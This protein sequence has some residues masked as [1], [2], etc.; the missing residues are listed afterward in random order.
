[1]KMNK[2]DLQ[3]MLEKSVSAALGTDTQT[4]QQTSEVSALAKSINALNAKVD[5][6]VDAASNG[7]EKPKTMEDH[8]ADMTK[9][10]KDAIGNLNKT[11][12]DKTSE[13]VK[14]PETAEELQK[15]IADSVAKALE[16]T[17]KV[18]TPKGET[19]E[20]D[21]VDP[22][23]KAIEDLDEDGINKLAK[24]LL[25]GSG[26]EGI[27]MS[28]D[29]IKETEDAAGNPLTALQKA[30]RAKLDDHFGKIISHSQ[31]RATGIDEEEEEDL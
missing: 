9:S 25:S 7:F 23:T 27:K 22:L 2:T 14:L 15:M 26:V 28:D 21:T 16:K 12:E 13:E 1:M 17:T 31:Q 5:A 30:K 4:E 6:I 20:D 3:A 24:D 18:E 11:T 8:F 29:L 19:S 10:I